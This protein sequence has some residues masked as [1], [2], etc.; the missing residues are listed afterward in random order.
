LGLSGR[1]PRRVDAATKAGVLEL[2]DGATDCGW[3]HRRACAYLELGEARAWRWRER[4]TAGTLA[5]CPAGGHAV[6]GLLDAEQE[7][8][9]ALYDD[10]SEIDRSHR[11][12]AHRGSY[13]RRVWVSPS[14]VMRV[15]AA[16]G[17]VLRAPRRAGRSE[18]RPFPEWASY[19]PQ[20]TDSVGRFRPG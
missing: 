19:Q 4:R 7:A 12:L 6:H 8:I 1:I 15:L 18:R 9:I 5:D 14:T 11:K 17:L 20:S 13:E 2:I 3:E 16:Q 10:W